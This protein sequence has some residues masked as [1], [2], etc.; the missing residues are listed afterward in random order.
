MAII[1][2]V[3]ISTRLLVYGMIS[4]LVVAFA[5][6][7]TFIASFLAPEY[8]LMGLLLGSVLGAFIA[9]HESSVVGCIC[10]MLLG[11]MAAPFIYYALD[12]ETTY[13]F[14]FVFSLIGAFLGEPF[15]YFWREADATNRGMM[16]GA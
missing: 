14:V 4:M 11:L 9:V 12:F 10:G 5:A 16:E 7:G 15:A 13:L 3:K 1:G 2:S 8:T 6:I